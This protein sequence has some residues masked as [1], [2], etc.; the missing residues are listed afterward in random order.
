MIILKCQYL[1]NKILSKFFNIYTKLSFSQTGEDLIIQFIIGSLQ[2]KKVTYLDVGTNHPFNMN[3]TFL[4]YLNGM[5]G[6]CVEPNPKL[7]NQIKRNRRRDKCL[8]VGV[9]INNEKTSTYYMMENSLLSTFSEEEANRMEKNGEAKI[10]KSIPMELININDLIKFNFTTCPD[11]ISLDAEGVDVEILNE[12]DFNT[13]RPKIFCIE[14][15]SY[16]TNLTGVKSEEIINLMS[17]NGYKIFADT[18]VNTI[19]IEEN[20]FN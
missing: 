13:Y 20:L 12:F 19:F 3:N 17:K 7:F 15:I 10:L 16:S 18:Y 5:N 4:M 6:V 2:L 8:N 9:G 11:V 1:F 14:T